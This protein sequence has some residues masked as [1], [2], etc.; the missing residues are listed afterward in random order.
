MHTLTLS[1]AVL[2]NQKACIQHLLH[3]ETY[4]NIRSLS[5]YEEL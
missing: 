5:G 3:Y 4:Y 2:L 1:V